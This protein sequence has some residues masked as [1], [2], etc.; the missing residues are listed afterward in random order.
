M[1]KTVSGERNDVNVNIVENWKKRLP[2]V[3][4][5]YDQKDI[6]NRDETALF[7][8]RENLQHFMLLVLI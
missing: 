4:K 7:S 5:D 8:N 2:T 6:F 3:C 1:F